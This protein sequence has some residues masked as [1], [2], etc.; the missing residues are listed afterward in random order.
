MTAKSQAERVTEL[1]TA[2]LAKANRRPEDELTIPTTDLGNAERLAAWH[3]DSLRYVDKWNRWLAWNG[4]CWR[5]DDTGAASRACQDVARRLAGMAAKHMAEAAAELAINR[6]DSDAQKMMKEAKALFEFALDSQNGRRLSAMEKIGRSLSAF[7]VSHEDLDADHWAL[8]VANG[9]LD[10]RTGTLR[11][12]DRADLITRLAPVA[13]DPDATC[14]TWDAFL[15]RAMGGSVSLTSYLQRLIGYSL[16]GTIREHLLGFF[17]GGGANG[18][19]TFLNIIHVL[20]GDYASTAPRGMLMRRTGTEPHPTE[21]VCMYGAR[22]VTCSEV[23]DGAALDEAKIKDLTGGD[24]IKARRMHE[25]FWEFAPTHKLFFAGNHRP[26]VRGDD[27]GIWRRLRLVPWTVTIPE[28]ERDTSLP[29]RLRA[30]LPGILA[31][32]VRGCL[33]W[34]AEGLSEPAEVRA[35]TSNY[36]AESDLVGQ[37][38]D[39]YCTFGEGQKVARKELRAAYTSW[40]EEQGAL[41]IGARKMAE[42]LRA[43]GVTD[44]SVRVAQRGEKHTATQVVDGWAGVRLST[45]TERAAHDRWKA[46]E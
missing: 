30:E 14:P 33:A 34:Q 12:H 42:R 23:E 7:V 10:L 8:N 6:D 13:Y 32:A 37:W 15:L 4:C 18:K 20:L 5:S 43:R 16:T 38:L 2:Q 41:P 39:A 22:F 21:A 17:F 24:R 35:A 29:D 11:P 46:A 9:T 26:A 3:G 25:N 45:D 36:R 19:S 44:T 28:A 31:W 27:D 1:K 40:C